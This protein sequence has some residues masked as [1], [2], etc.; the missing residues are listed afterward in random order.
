[1]SPTT[2]TG[3]ASPTWRASAWT[4]P[5]W[6]VLVSLLLPVVA[7][8]AFLGTQILVVPEVAPFFLAFV[9]LGAVIVW[10]ADRWL[11]LAGGVVA[12]AFAAL[13]FAFIYGELVRP[14]HYPIYFL[15]WLA[16][17][18]GLA[19]L[20]GGVAGFVDARRHRFGSPRWGG[21]GAALVLLGA[22]FA[23]GSLVA[24]AGMHLAQTPV[25]ASVSLVPDASVEVSIESFAF[26]GGTIAI[27][28][29]RIVKLTLT[30]ADPETHTFTID[31]LAIDQDVPA[32]KGAEVWL[33]APPGTYEVY[34]K[35][36]STAVEGD[37]EGMVA[38]LVVT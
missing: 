35:P 25:A 2:A 20:T 38:T 31:A 18:G 26:G 3:A 13:N 37:R 30:N 19:G 23:G 1:M 7:L 27:P 16:V 8:P 28:A 10:R 17:L 21:I 32:G 22:G 14:D 24:T 5:R 6:T 4:L 34:C 29:D 15:A 11:L 9:L 36:H 33:R 12:F